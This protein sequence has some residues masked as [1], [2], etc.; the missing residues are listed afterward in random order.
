M[1][2][3]AKTLSG[4]RWTASVRLASQVISWAITLLVVRILTPADY[5]LLA[6]AT[7]FIMFFQM[8]AELGLGP[9][10][11]QK[12]E[13]GLDMMKQTF[14]IVLAINVG[15]A[16]ILFLAAP[17]IA[18]FYSEPK[19]TLLIRVLSLQFLLGALNVI[20]SVQLLR[21]M[22][23]RSRSLLDLIETILA[24]C[25]TLGVAWA[26]GGVWS[27]VAGTF[28]GQ[29]LH[30][31][32]MNWL[33]P[34]PHLP[35]FSLK[36]M[37]SVLTFGGNMTLAGM[38]GM[39]CA[40]S[41]TFI[42]ARILGNELYGFYS[43]GVNLASLPSQKLNGLVNGVAFPAFSSIQGDLARVSQYVLLGIRVL[44]CFA[45]P[46]LWGMSSI[47]PEIVEV[48]LG[49]KWMM[50]ILPLQVLALVV[51]LRIFANFVGTATQGLGRTDLT[52]RNTCRALLIGPPLLFLGT[53]VGG[54]TGLSL[55]SLIIAPAVYLPF[56]VSCAPVLGLRPRQ[57]F[58]ALSSPAG[59]A[60][61]MYAAVFA[62]RHLIGDELHGAMRMCVLI[63]VGALSYLGA[64]LVIDRKGA[65]QVLDVVRSIVVTKRA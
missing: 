36:G 14:G 29:I 54:L 39:F 45:F 33:S 6:M 20:P 42:G 22:E 28:V 13:L 32:G 3:R 11:V 35:S 23:Y 64:S 65:L 51:P 9:A 4:F 30:T 62:V 5:G 41:D 59:A 56:Y 57:F 55:V 24:S 7:A 58:Q 60:L 2:L 37:R 1:T 44:A 46:V 61:I 50:S 63:A 31:I 25:T 12:A 8:F 19:V 38:I 53:S 10:L 48:I 43:V 17:L 21:R 52:L 18:A 40:Q 49:P 27:L 34:F 15:L 26:G 47:A 16:L